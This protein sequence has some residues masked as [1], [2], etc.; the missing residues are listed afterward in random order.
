MVVRIENISTNISNKELKA[1]ISQ[2]GEI[3]S[4]V[5]SGT[6]AIVQMSKEQDVRKLLCEF[7]GMDLDGSTVKTKAKI[8]PTSSEVGCN[9]QL[10]SVR[11]L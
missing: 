8:N 6:T 3:R 11:L 9:G 4:M 2:F 1:L 7:N 10:G 5:R